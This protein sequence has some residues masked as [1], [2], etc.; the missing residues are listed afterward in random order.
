M[1][2][3][4]IDIDT[5]RPDHLGCYGYH[6]NTSPNLD[7]LAAEG[8]RFTNYYVT[9]APCLPARSALTTGQFG[10]HNQV[11]NHGGTNADPL[12]EGVNREFKQEL[13]GGS[14]FGTLRR[15]GFYT[16][17]ISP[18]GERHSAWQFYAGLNEMLNPAGKSGQERADEVEPVALDWIERNKDRDN[19]FLHV[20]V[21]DP[22][23]PY[24][25]PMEYGNPFANDPPPAWLTQETIDRHRA[26]FGT[27]SAAD[28]MPYTNPGLSQRCPRVPDDI[29]TVA[30]FRKWIDGYDVGIRYA[31][32]FVGRL[33]GRLK[34]LGLYDDTVILVTS[35]HGENQGELNIYGDHHTA[36]HITSRV[37]MI[38]RWPGVAK[39]GGVD[40]GLHYQIDLQPTLAE[41]L[42][43]KPHAAWDGRSYVTS[44]R[45]P[46]SAGRDFLVLS[47]MAWSC[48]RS[49]RWDDAEGHWILLRT[50][51]TGF[52]ELA[53]VMLFN[54]ADDPHET[55][56]L[57]AARPDKVNEG[58]AR[59][60]SWHA[61]QMATSPH[62]VDPLQVILREGGPYHTSRQLATYCEHLRKTGRPHHADHLEAQYGRTNLR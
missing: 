42:G 9:D 45:S 59:L 19:W 28:V 49:V 52:K 48:Q 8:V 60:E 7:R 5:L 24:R 35:D 20:N 61:E 57:A 56:D 43:A 62:G 4:M 18:F 50:Y 16:A 36:D 13:Q 27:H 37:P 31:D 30:D 41:L 33:V 55:R 1:R 6:R 12:P 23:T 38:V 17:S 29:R 46:G 34:E 14:F 26:G 53:P 22:H 40:T 58:L 47:Q 32:D 54:I 21:W 2:F 51:H 25:V 15:A 3:L 10:I 11:V 44:L 39:A